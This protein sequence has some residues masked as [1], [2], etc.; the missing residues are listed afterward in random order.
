MGCGSST[1][2]P[3]A[4]N[5]TIKATNTEKVEDKPRRQSALLSA[6]SESQKEIKKVTHRE[7]GSSSARRKSSKTPALNPAV[8]V[9]HEAN[10]DDRRSSKPS[11]H[12]L[13]VEM[14]EEERKEGGPESARKRNLLKEEEDKRK[15]DKE[16]KERKQKLDEERFTLAERIVLTAPMEKVW[17]IIKDWELNYLKKFSSDVRVSV[18]E[19]DGQRTRTVNIPNL[20]GAV[21][22]TLLVCD[23]VKHEI[24]YVMNASPLPYKEHSVH[25][26]LEQPSPGECVVVWNSSAV[27][28]NKTKEEARAIAKEGLEG[29]I[30]RMKQA[31][32]Q[33]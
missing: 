30:I 28:S 20:D 32:L 24:A 8:F 25:I 12:N 26:Q 2:Q 15:K 13:T 5:I 11:P 23:D 29:A 10:K 16:E 4:S 9:V 3:P 22:E 7:D 17:L 14:K 1:Q 27:P 31:V 21:E 33:S 6:K 19:K 18:G